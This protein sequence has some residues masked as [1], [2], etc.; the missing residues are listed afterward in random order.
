MEQRWS[1]VARA[2]TALDFRRGV[3]Y[4]LASD[5]GKWFEEDGFEYTAHGIS[6]QLSR[7]RRGSRTSLMLQERV[8]PMI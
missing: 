8:A 2:R 3:R 7:G 5:D 4:T 6:A 1:H